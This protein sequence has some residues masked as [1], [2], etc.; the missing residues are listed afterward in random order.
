VPTSTPSIDQRFEAF[1][2]RNPEILEQLIQLAR[3]AKARGFRSYTIKGLWEVVRFRSDPVTAERYRMNNDFTSRYARLVMASEPSLK[4]F[5]TTREIGT[6]HTIDA[7]EQYLND[8][9][10][11]V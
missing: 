5:F 6:D 11:A 7:R 9:L 4:G 8:L 10:G 2:A 1:H 3:A